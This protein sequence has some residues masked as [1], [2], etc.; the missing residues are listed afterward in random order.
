[1]PAVDL[2]NR[3]VWLS[4]F[5]KPLSVVDLPV[6]NAN[7]GTAVVKIL[8][9]GVAPYTHLIHSGKLPALKLTPPLVPNLSGIGR[10][11]DV[12]PDAV[13]LKKGD[14]VFIDGL[15][16]ARD[17]ANVALMPGHMTGGHP[18]ALKLMRGLTRRF[19]ATISK[20]STGNLLS[21]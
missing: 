6:P 13:R 21:T 8:A 7:V 11:H 9:T 14:L 5:S 17:D 3:A 16:R 19:L 18:N 1:M 15:I 10:I 2:T 4:S 12:G 20:G